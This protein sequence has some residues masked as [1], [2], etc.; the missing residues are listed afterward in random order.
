MATVKRYRFDILLAGSDQI[1]RPK[2]NRY[3]TDMFFQFATLWPIKKIVYGA[4]FGTDR[5]EYD[6]QT[7]RRCRDL[8]K[9]IDAVSVRE[10]SGVEL[11]QNYFGIAAEW[12]LDPT[13]LLDVSDYER[14]C[15]SIPRSEK[16]FMAVYMLDI[17][18][19]MLNKINKMAQEVDIPIKVF[20]ADYDTSLSIEEWLAMFRD[21]KYI[22]T[23][24]FH[25]TV[26][27]IIFNKTFL[28]IGNQGRGMSRFHSLLGLFGL[29]DRLSQ[30]ISVERLLQPV[31]WNEI[32]RQKE[33]LKDK[34]IFFLETAL[35][36]MTTSVH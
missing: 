3:L 23:D 12:V 34:S 18:K 5:W 1:W 8:V 30:D 4:S 16:D 35:R 21:A 19:Q 7:T 26:F 25:G 32:N 33:V 2:Y 28:S 17:D 10:K 6:F 13:M 20:F 11:C 36:G 31:P 24:S 15:T 27:S 9:Q 29:E 14:L 22:I